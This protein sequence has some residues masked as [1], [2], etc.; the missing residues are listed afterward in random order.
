MIFSTIFNG[1]KK[2]PD[3][4][5]VTVGLLTGTT[6]TSAATEVYDSVNPLADPFW[7]DPTAPIR[8]LLSPEVGVDQFA[9]ILTQLGDTMMFVLLAVG[10]LAFLVLFRR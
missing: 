3:V 9:D 10:V 5:K 1:I 2:L 7:S 6:S 8:D 4:F